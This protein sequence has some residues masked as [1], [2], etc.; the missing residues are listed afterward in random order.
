MTVTLCQQPCIVTVIG[1]LHARH[2]LAVIDVRS[3]S[4]SLGIIVFPA[5]GIVAS[6]LNRAG[7]T[8]SVASVHIPVVTLLSRFDDAI[9]VAGSRR[10]PPPPC[11]QAV[12][13]CHPSHREDESHCH[14]CRRSA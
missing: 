9:D 8:A 14:D 10:R 2:R 3:R 1:P 11:L 4:G 7:R 13:E 12:A 6:E 5:I